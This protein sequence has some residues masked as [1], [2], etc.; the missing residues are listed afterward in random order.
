LNRR[1]EFATGGLVLLFV[2]AHLP[3]LPQSLEDL[4][5][6]NFAL[7]VRSFDVTRHQPH[8][9]GYP[10]FILL[11]KA[12]HALIPSEA[13]ALAIVSVAAGALAIVALVRLYT[14]LEPGDRAWE[15]PLFST[16]V[17]VTCPLFWVTAI[18]PLSDVAGLAA[19]LGVQAA[20]LAASTPAGL[21]AASFLAALA[22]GIR[23]Q[24]AW[25]TVPLLMLAIARQR[26]F[27]WPTLAFVAGVLIWAVPLVVLT[28]GPAA[29]WRV[30]ST[31]GAEDLSGVVMLST[32]PTIRELALTLYYAFLVPWGIWQLGVLIVVLGSAGFGWL[33]RRNRDGAVALAFA[34]GPYLLFDLFFQETVTSRYALPLAVPVAY[35]AVLGARLLPRRTALMVVSAVVVAGVAIGGPTLYAYSRMEAPA[36]RL[37]GDM[38]AAEAAR[39]EQPPVLAMHRRE[40]FDLRRPFDWVG[41]AA[42]RFG[43]RLPSVPKHEWMQL[44]NYWNGGGRGAIWFVADPLRSDLAL[45]AHGQ[46]R[47]FRW[48]FSVPILF[49]GM[50]PSEMDWYALEMPDWYLGEGWAVTPETAGIAREDRRGP[51][52]APVHGWMR[53]VL[54]RSTLMIGGRNLADGGPPARFTIT[55]DGRTVDDVTVAPGFFLRMIDLPPADPAL[56]GD[57]STIAVSADRPDVA[58]EQ[59]D[60]KPSGAVVFGYGDGWHEEEYVPATGALWHWTS[61]RASL[62]VRSDERASVLRLT[63]ETET[64][65]KRSHVVIQS[66]GQKLTDLT[67]GSTFSIAVGLPAEIFKHGEA[68]ITISTDQ[69]YVPTDRLFRRSNDHRHLGLKIYE[70]SITPAS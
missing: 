66:A 54:G 29:Y 33:T 37:L 65:R 27:V 41:G 18:R 62:L 21:A 24:V 47:R 1:I 56:T 52:I 42:P 19:A 50:R 2:A 25:L 61:E 70:C 5:S 17:A 11:A 26:S 57:Y 60:A 31:Q 46:P 44:V 32:T 7:G 20:T 9:P 43:T 55:V 34:F 14:L 15:V 16:V 12:V 45:I 64:F 49:G 36:F 10:L 6:I 13:R 4:D 67:V 39:P 28:G 48:G 69:I 51:G 3:F 30:F 22:I 35:L 59:F 8:P 23:S 68:T 53:R 63:G 58:I 38:G 40:E